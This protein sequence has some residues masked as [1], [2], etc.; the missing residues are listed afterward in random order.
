MLVMA[1]FQWW[2]GPGWRDTGRRL[3]SFVHTTYLTFSVAALIR[4]LFA[5]WK[6]IIASSNGSLQ[7]KSRS[8]VD[9][10]VSRAVGFAVRLIT[11]IAALVTI[12]V[13][14]VIG[15]LILILWPILPLLGPALIVGGI[16]L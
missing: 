6:R 3:I 12:A 7:Q 4:T 10:A 1:F 14:S 8:M 15:G 13:A 16:I 11:L 2:Y 9:N 5:P